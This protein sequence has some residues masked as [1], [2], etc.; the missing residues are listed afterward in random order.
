MRGQYVS[1]AKAAMVD[2][3]PDVSEPADT[4]QDVS[5]TIA[6]TGSESSG[7]GSLP[8]SA[9]GAHANE[10]LLSAAYVSLSRP[11]V[12]CLQQQC[13]FQ[14]PLQPL[15]PKMPS[16]CSSAGVI[17]SGYAY[18]CA[19]TFFCN[20]LV[21]IFKLLVE[22]AVFIQTAFGSHLLL[23]RI[24]YANTFQLFVSSMLN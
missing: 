3:Q 20:L 8:T 15:L 6:D 1:V 11:A 4:G 21:C 16:T 19:S 2:N 23:T 18:I 9:P 10:S 5:K 12:R 17:A 24:A 13:S 14:S 7:A 22:H